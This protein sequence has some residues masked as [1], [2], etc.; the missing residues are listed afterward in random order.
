MCRNIAVRGRRRIQR[1]NWIRY[2]DF[3]KTNEEII[4]KIKSFTKKD[5]VSRFECS[6]EVMRLRAEERPLKQ[7]IRMPLVTFVTAVSGVSA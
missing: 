7:V 5:M 3:Q 4:M 1:G 6:Q 2:I